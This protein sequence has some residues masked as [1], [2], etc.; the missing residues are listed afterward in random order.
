MLKQ[1]V[2]SLEGIIEAGISIR[3]ILSTPLMDDSCKN[4]R[5]TQNYD[6]ACSLYYANTCLKQFIVKDGG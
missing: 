3:N 2:I 6:G 4:W 1:K 5:C